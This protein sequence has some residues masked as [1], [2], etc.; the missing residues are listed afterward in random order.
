MLAYS[1]GLRPRSAH[2]W[3]R[4]GEVEAASTVSRADRCS[5][6]RSCFQVGLPAYG[7][8]RPTYRWQGLGRT[9]DPTPV[10]MGGWACTFP[11]QSDYV[12]RRHAMTMDRR[13]LLKAGVVATTGGLLAPTVGALTSAVTAAPTV[14][15]VLAT[16]LG[17]PWGVAFLP[18]GERGC[19]R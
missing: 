11:T 9:A 18:R 7:G 15:R 6:T 13:T 14:E 8:Q 10:R 19:A 4:S 1:S 2:G 5:V 12:A 3:D 16:G 17:V